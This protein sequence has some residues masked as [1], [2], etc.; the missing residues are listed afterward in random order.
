[1]ISDDESKVEFPFEQPPDH[2]V[3]RANADL[4][5]NFW[6]RGDLAHDHSEVRSPLAGFGH[7]ISDDPAWARHLPSDAFAEILNLIKNRL[8]ELEKL[9]C[10]LRGKNL[11]SHALKQLHS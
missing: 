1:M 6:K 3:A 7:G 8:R 2:L 10:M 11:M 4:E 9:A 5:L